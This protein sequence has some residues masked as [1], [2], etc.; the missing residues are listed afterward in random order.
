MILPGASDG[1]VGE[2]TRATAEK[3]KR[4]YEF[5]R[6]RIRERVFGAGAEATPA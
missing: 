3:G 1:S 4:I 2:P 6:G 5:I